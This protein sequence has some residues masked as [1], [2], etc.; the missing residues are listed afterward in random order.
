MRSRARHLASWALFCAG[1]AGASAPPAVPSE[2]PPVSSAAPLAS[3]S[4]AEPVEPPTPLPVAAPAALL[5]EAKTKPVEQTTRELGKILGLPLELLLISLGPEVL[6][7]DAGLGAAMLL[8]ERSADGLV[9]PLLAAVSVPVRSERAFEAAIERERSVWKPRAGGFLR[10]QGPLAGLLC[11][12]VV[13]LGDAP[14]RAVCAFDEDSLARVAPYLTR[15]LP[16]ADLGPGDLRLRM[17]LSSTRPRL[18]GPLGELKQQQ[19]DLLG[20]PGALLLGGLLDTSLLSAPEAILDE[21][22]RFV[23][24]QESLS[25][26]LRLD[27]KERIIELEG[28]WKF[29]SSESWLV[30]LMTSRAERGPAPE[31]FWRL[32]GASEAALFGRGVDGAMQ[33]EPRRVGRKAVSFLLERTGMEPADV[34]AVDE[35]LRAIPLGDH[36]WALGAGGSGQDGWWLLGSEGGPGEFPGWVRKVGQALQR[37]AALARK[38]GAGAQDALAGLKV[39]NAPAGFP[40]GSV[41]IESSAAL[42]SE[43]LSGVLTGAGLPLTRGEPL[44]IVAFPEGKSRSW[45][46]VASRR[47][48]LKK[49]TMQVVQGPGKEL[50]GAEA[51]LESLRTGQHGF[52]GR[53]LTPGGDDSAPGSPVL[54]HGGVQRGTLDLRARIPGAPVGSL[55]RGPLL[56]GSS[57]Q[58]VIPKGSWLRA[59]LRSP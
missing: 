15:G 53:L 6:R 24:A 39:E 41:L 17:P 37:A 12:T 20:G 11:K 30:R 52:G 46:G 8:G 32:P 44:L 43:L 36:P 51:G 35:A 10:T 31:V 13:S 4:A 47:S 7:T 59:L 18:S 25:L 2:P 57:F 33:E 42:G 55:L 16:L 34:R 45:L 54:L 3:A 27:G 5:L 38:Q 29:S 19:S 58:G 23:E 22:L 14:L 28:I 26:G 50:L 1:C 56:Q 21:G 40:Q 49:P 9:P 48:A